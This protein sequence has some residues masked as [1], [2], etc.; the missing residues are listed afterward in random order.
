[1]TMLECIAMNPIL[2]TA[3]IGVFTIGVCVIIALRGQS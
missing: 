3:V 1:M 2:T